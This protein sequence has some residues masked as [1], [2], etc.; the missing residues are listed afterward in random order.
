MI[1]KTLWKYKFYIIIPFLLGLIIT[2]IL[3]IFSVGPQKG[4]FIYQIH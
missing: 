2:V 4:P 1:R 3:M